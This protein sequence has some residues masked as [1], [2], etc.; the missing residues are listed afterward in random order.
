MNNPMQTK[1]RKTQLEVNFPTSDKYIE[2][3]AKH[4]HPNHLKK[5][6]VFPTAF[7]R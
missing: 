4:P 1:Q 3:F 5:C 6:P 7:R 2:R